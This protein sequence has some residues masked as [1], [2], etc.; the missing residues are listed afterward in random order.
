MSFQDRL[1]M[2][3]PIETWPSLYSA[4]LER[5]WDGIDLATSPEAR[6]TAAIYLMGYVAEML[7]KVAFFRVTGFP[8][9]QAVDLRAI[10]THAAWTKANLH[11]LD[12]LTDLLI[13]ER[14]L[15]GRA[16]DP[17]FAG[18]LKACVLTVA[19]HWRETLRY[20]H[21]PA[22]ETE[23]VE[24]YQNVDWLRANATLLWS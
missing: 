15:R 22:A 3:E 13:A 4:A 2:L 20:R 5:Y 6:R 14:G 23:L 1:Q 10:T 17:V 24:V 21:T 7:L 12:G 19:S 8:P 18:Q 11:N 9:G 16:F